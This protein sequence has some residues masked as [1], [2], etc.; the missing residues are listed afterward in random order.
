MIV[1]SQGLSDGV[2]VVPGGMID[3]WRMNTM[4]PAEGW[5][6][7]IERQMGIQ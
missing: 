5:C 3:D 2:G 7:E 6:E 1:S 4:F